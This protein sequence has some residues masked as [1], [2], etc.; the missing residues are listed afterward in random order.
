MT[1]KKERK[2]SQI[3]LS[4]ILIMVVLFGIIPYILFIVSGVRSTIEK[5]TILMDKH[6]VE[7]RQV[8]LENEMV[9]HWTKIYKE[10][11]ILSTALQQILNEKNIQVDQFLSNPDI[12]QEYLENVFDDMTEALQYNTASGV[13]L[14]LANNNSVEEESS[15][16]GFFLRDSD[17]QNKIA[18]NTDLLL[19]RG[20]K[21]LSQKSTI[22]LDSGWTTNFT[23]MGNGMRKSDDFFYKPYMAALQFN[24]AD[25]EKLG[26]WSEPFVL[27]DNNIDSHQMITYSVPLSYYGTIYAVIGVE[28]GIDYLT[29]Y[30]TVK[31]LDENLNAGYTLAVKVSG[32]TYR[33]AVGKGSLYNAVKDSKGLFE[34]EKQSEKDLY[35][36]KDAKIGKQDIYCVY[37]M[38]D[39]YS[40]NVPY[41]NTQW[42]LCGLVTEESIYGISTQLYNKMIIAM[43]FSIV[44]A[45]VI[46]NIIIK[47]VTRP[48]YRLMESVRKGVNGIHDFP[49]SH[50]SEIDELHD[51]V[52][53]LTDL[54]KHNEELLL[55]EK[56]R[57]RIAVKNSQDA[58]FIF[59]AKDRM[60]EIVNSKENDGLWDCWNHPE[61]IYNNN[62]YPDDAD[63]VYDT[64]DKL[65]KEINIEFRLR[66]ADDAEYKWVNMT[67][68]IMRNTEG[69]LI[70]IIGC[71]R[72]IHEAKLYEE[73]RKNRKNYDSLTSY[74]RLS[75]GLKMIRKYADKYEK[76]SFLLFDI[77]KFSAI[78]ENY[79][80]VFG[81]VLVEQLAVIIK[82]QCNKANIHNQICIR[83]G[84]DQ[85]LIWCP[86]VDTDRAYKLAQ[87][88][89]T[90]FSSLINENYYAISFYCGIAQ[91]GLEFDKEKD[92][93]AVKC[94]LAIAKMTK[95]TI[96]IAKTVHE[97]ELTNISESEFV[98]I[99]PINHLK[100]LRLSSLAMN[101]LDRGDDIHVIL[102][103]LVCKMLEKYEFDN[104]IITEFMNEELASSCLYV[105]K[106]EE[107]LSGEVTRCTESQ[108]Q[109]FLKSTNTQQIVAVEGDEGNEIVLGSFGKMRGVAYNMLDD[110]HY[111]GSIIFAGMSSDVLEDE[112]SRKQ[113]EEISVII[114][115]RINLQ[116][117]DLSAKAKTEFL[118]RMS[119]EIRTPMNGI[120]GMTEIALQDGQNETNRIECLKKIKSS[121]NYLLG[122]LNDILDMSKIESGKMKLV[123]EKAN[124]AK[125][126][127][128]ITPM[129]EARI[130]SK[131][132]N[133][134]TDVELKHSWFVFDSLRINQ[135]LV[136][137]LSNAIKYSNTGGNI[138]LTV[139][140]SIINDK[141]SELYFAVSDD[142]AGIA[143]NRQ[144]AVFR[145]F[146]QADDSKLAR[147]QGTGLGLTISNRLVHMMD[148]DINLESEVGKGSTFSF[149][150]RF[151]VVPED[152]VVSN[153]DSNSYDFTG[154]RVLAVEDN[155]LN[156]EIVKTLLEKYGIIVDEAY[157]GQQ[158]VDI[159]MKAKPHYY[160]L[161]LMDIMMPVMDGLEA[162]R[163]IRQMDSEYCHNVPI[164]AMSA[165]AFDEDVKR[166][167]ECGMNDHISKPINVSKLE[168][169]LSIMQNFDMKRGK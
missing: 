45:F 120:I 156:M 93:R 128:D 72:N 87:D 14:V 150:V 139:K 18:T 20:S 4:P 79:G 131:S 40:N 17:P 42:V 66:S 74:Y 132:I 143:D 145:S 27:E 101:I 26:Y 126:I 152:I 100:E 80:L 76:N 1:L 22:P 12:Q 99:N 153:E 10:N 115:N 102:D 157:D 155:E 11:E 15:Y 148:S 107:H 119:H 110:M 48:V 73:A 43:I 164:I 162:T 125:L 64:I 136:N 88:I 161:I 154:K 123:K 95:R 60:L 168:R 160:D 90:E 97:D 51:V 25:M 91:T 46:V 16:Q 169:A 41:D 47:N 57:Y 140:E 7:N 122:L 121:S 98:D 129:I 54:Q 137:F 114:Q 142:G 24:S 8:V 104:L 116:R 85:L 146:E 37:S 134:V 165:N 149:S 75:Y 68:S 105:Y 49:V 61:Y 70:L 5:N 52:E 158:A 92:V 50:I 35:K 29:D 53:N 58:F 31:D 21:E 84:A 69:K 59:R 33:N 144:E 44:C 78:D 133:Y 34:L 6:V 62:I 89:H 55:E 83:A 112:H 67:G 163:R 113:L 109:E 38:I 135:I 77:A 103:I 19:E 56:E 13:F 3:L 141:E 81:D 71:I 82:A 111:S 9:E 124:L 106:D 147:R 2:L 96:V 23:L 118:A 36:V 138:R 86:R 130:D 167:L 117:H 65:E 39:L 94:A 32:D 166:S 30:F 108:R 151:E 28:I 63:T 127:E 159:M